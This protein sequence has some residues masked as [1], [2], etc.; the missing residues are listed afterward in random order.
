MSQKWYPVI[1]YT[2]CVECGSC[3]EKCIHGVYDTAKMPS[4]VVVHT[5]NC[6]DHCHGCGNLCPEGAITYVGEDTGWS[7]PN[8]AGKDSGSSC[9]CGCR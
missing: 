3:T 6:I 5:E 2:S 8:V 9:C 1:D 7:S 4:P